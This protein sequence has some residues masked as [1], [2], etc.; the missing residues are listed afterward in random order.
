M[1]WKES[2]ENSFYKVLIEFLGLFADLS[3]SLNYIC[4]IVDF[5][6]QVRPSLKTNENSS[7]AKSHLTITDKH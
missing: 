3:L 4:L 1:R 7:K 2:I 5:I 6:L